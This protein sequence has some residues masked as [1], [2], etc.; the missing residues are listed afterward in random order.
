MLNDRSK[1]T[2]FGEKPSKLSIF[3]PFCRKLWLK[4][5][6]SKFGKFHVSGM[7]PKKLLC[8]RVS[9]VSCVVLNKLGS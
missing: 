4:S 8:D 7:K 2:S 6:E 5:S 3:A 9:D 1:L